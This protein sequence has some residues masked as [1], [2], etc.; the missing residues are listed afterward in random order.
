MFNGFIIVLK[1]EFWTLLSLLINFNMR[2]SAVISR[3][4]FPPPYKLLMLLTLSLT[5]AE[6]LRPRTVICVERLSLDGVAILSIIYMLYVNVFT[7]TL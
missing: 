6:A 7:H 1:A 4:I 3:D 2:F 5:V